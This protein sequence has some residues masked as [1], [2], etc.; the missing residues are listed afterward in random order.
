[1][2]R[3]WGPGRIGYGSMLAGCDLQKLP[4]RPPG[5]LSKGLYNGRTN[6]CGGKLLLPHRYRS[7]VHGRSRPK[8]V[9]SDPIR[10]SRRADIRGGRVPT[11]SRPVIE[12]PASAARKNGH[13]GPGRRRWGG[14]MPFRAEQANG[15][16]APTTAVRSNGGA[17]RERASR[18]R[19]R[20]A[21]LGGNGPSGFGHN[22]PTAAIQLLS[23]DF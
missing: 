17:S 7:G 16:S 3:R 4:K 20:S 5:K 19:T 6:R 21:A 10:Q 23:A 1:M 22:T 12:A 2:N 18:C 9:A 8:P 13:C 15:R 11:A 14:S